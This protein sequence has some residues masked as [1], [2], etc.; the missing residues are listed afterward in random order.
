MESNFKNLINY[1]INLSEFKALARVKDL[2]CISLYLPFNNIKNDGI[3]LINKHINHSIPK[4]TAY[5][6]QNQLTGNDIRDH[7]KNILSVFNDLK[8]CN[9][10][11]KSL[12]IFIKKGQVNCYFTSKQIQFTCYIH[13][14]FYLKPI[15]NLFNKIE[16]IN[17]TQIIQK[18]PAE[19]IKTDIQKIIELSVSGKITNLFINKEMDVYG[20]VDFENMFVIPV[21]E[22]QKGSSLSNIAAIHTILNQGNV[23][24]IN[25][26]EIQKTTTPIIGIQA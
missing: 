20:E 6:K 8:N 23:F 12:A 11:G 17:P 14:H 1:T 3:K 2:C 7:V 16:N 21:K 22:N 18:F 13:N 15:S 10:K 19:K 25:P 4:I 26:S 24:L 5:L 9:F